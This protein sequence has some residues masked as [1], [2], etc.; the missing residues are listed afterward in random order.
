MFVHSGHASMRLTPTFAR[1]TAAHAASVPPVSAS[2]LP[3]WSS[4]D[5]VCGFSGTGP[6]IYVAPPAQDAPPAN[7]WMS[8]YY[9]SGLWIWDGTRNQWSA[10]NYGR[11]SQSNPYDLFAWYHGPPFIEFQSYSIPLHNV[12]IYTWAQVKFNYSTNWDN[13]SWGIGGTTYS[14][15][16]YYLHNDTNYFVGEVNGGCYFP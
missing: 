13:V 7:N 15:G 14:R 9:Q 10:F 3:Y 12:Y 5:A 11:W 8:E 1:A 2:N 16:T 6:F 4:G